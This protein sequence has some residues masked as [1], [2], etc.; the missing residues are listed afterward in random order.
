MAQKFLEKKLI[1]LQKRTVALKF[2]SAVGPAVA[3]AIK[4]IVLIKSRVQH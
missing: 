4:S 2:L 1:P 3:A